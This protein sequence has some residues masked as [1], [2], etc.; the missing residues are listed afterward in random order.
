LEE[1]NILRICAILHDIGKPECWAM[2]RPW[3]EHIYYTHEIIKRSLGDKYA[4]IAMRHHTG[5]SYPSKYHPETELEKI[6]WLS[7]NLASG[8]D[9][10]EMPEAGAHLPS[11]PIRLSHVLSRGEKTIGES[12]EDSLL[13]AAGEA[14]ELL[15]KAA[16]NMDT[17]YPSIFE[18]MRSSR[19]RLIPADTRPPINDVSLW[20]HLKLTAA[21]S[22]CIWLSGGY[23]GE[24]PEKYT[25]ALV[26]GDADRVS[27]YVN[28]ALRLPDLNARSRKI[29]DATEAAALTIERML[30]P[31]CL[32]YGGGGGFL[33][34]SPPGLADELASEAKRAFE[35]ATQGGV[36]ITTTYVVEDGEAIQAFGKVWRSCIREMRLKK[37][38]RPEPIPMNLEEDAAPCD[39]CG[40]KPGR[41]EDPTKLL[42]T[43]PARP[44]ILCEE[45]WNLRAEGR[46]YA[47]KASLDEIKGEADYVAV[48]KADG[49]DIGRILQGD[50]LEEFGKSSTP[51]RL[52][53]ISSLIHETCE[54]RLRSVIGKFGGV[55]LY[56]GG[57]DLL[58]ILPGENALEAAREIASS[59][60]ESMAGRCSIS[61]GVSIFHYKL[62]VYVGLE[63][64]RGLLERAKGREGKN[65]IAFA[66]IGGSGIP[67]KALSEIKPYGWSELDELLG[68]I[69]YLQDSGLPMSQIR[70]IAGLSGRD[71]QGAEILIKY[72]VGRGVISWSAGRRL[73]EHTESGLLHNA[74]L[75]FNAFRGGGRG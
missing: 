71:L 60:G 47:E 5:A 41:Y 15:R 51:S 11:L 3:S 52:A 24:D 50:K 36:S 66:I 32:I 22:T 28:R 27:D 65:S 68:T 29:I 63:A 40:V 67:E 31:E 16:G 20:D 58:A 14:A 44:E 62:P 59:F 4:K 69:R 7:D 49:D 1:L 37:L 12:D 56:A 45:C 43:V 26:S 46:K 18:G 10:R 9:R 54:R 19:L 74:F 8:A 2:R 48:L 34:L 33:A 55:C 70:R 23:R 25:F 39:V 53:A 75:V 6:I 13:L 38:E 61:T 42:P 21:F 64:S 35:E 73:L 17:A 30:G 57:D 72:L